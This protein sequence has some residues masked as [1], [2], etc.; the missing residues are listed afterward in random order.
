[1]KRIAFISTAAAATVGAIVVMAASASTAWSQSTR[2]S[3]R[4]TAAA[5]APATTQPQDRDGRSPFRGRFDG[6]PGDGARQRMEWR[7]G[8]LPN[9]P[10]PENFTEP[11]AEEWKEIEAFMKANSPERL[12]HLEDI[13]EDRQQSVKNMFAA[14]YRALQELKEQDPEM[15]QIRVARMPIEDKAFELS[16]KL[17][18]NRGKVAKT[19]DTKAQLRTQLRLLVTSR[20]D[21]RALRLRHLEKHLA[22]ERE[23]LKEDEK[24]VDE[25]VESNLADV[26]EDRIPRDLR[27]QLMPRRERPRD[28]GS[29][30]NASPADP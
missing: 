20:L 15:Y 14:R 6:R 26:A 12:Q 23:K 5:T 21:E 8:G 16:W 4:A 3:G 18:H 13:S 2:P 9:E 29:G 19:D 28:D 22:D 7:R 1:V 10:R 24:H 27:P 25:L 17:T 30:V 11:T